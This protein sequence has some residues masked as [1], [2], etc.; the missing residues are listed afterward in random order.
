MVPSQR[1][2]ERW[3]DPQNGGQELVLGS[4]DAQSTEQGVLG[5]HPRTPKPPGGTGSPS[6]EVV[7]NIQFP[8]SCERGCGHVGMEGRGRG[9]LK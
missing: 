1:G 4:P 6:T 3:G 8:P 2:P 5:H 9:T 7:R